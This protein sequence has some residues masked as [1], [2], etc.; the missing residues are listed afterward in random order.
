MTG[1]LTRVVVVEDEPVIALNLQQQLV[2]L[3][4]EVVGVAASGESALDQIV[5]QRPDVV[6]MDIR[7]EGELDGIETAARIPGDL[8]IVLIFL[9]G[10]F[11]DMTF[12][13]AREAKPYGFLVKP[14]SDW[15]LHA[16]IQMALDRRRIDAALRA[17]ERQL[18]ESNSRLRAEQ[19]TNL[20]LSLVATHTTNSVII[21]NSNGAIDWV[22]EA[23]T[24]TTGYSLAEVRGK[25]ALSLL[26]GPDS[27]P[28]TIALAR[29]RILLGEG[30]R[31]LELLNYT[32]AGEPYWVNV[33]ALPIRDADGT[34]VQIVSIGT[35]VTARKAAEAEIKASYDKFAGSFHRSTEAMAVFTIGA[36][37]G[38]GI[39]K[40]LN[41]AAERLF[42]VSRDDVIGRTVLEFPVFVDS[43]QIMEC[44]QQLRSEG[45]L[46]DYSI[47][48]RRSDG[49]T[50]AG[51]ITASPFL[52]AGQPHLIVIFRDVTE[53]RAAERR[54]RELNQSLEA[55]LRQ[56]RAIADNVPASIVYLDAEERYRFMNL[57]AERWLATKFE[58]VEGR[59]I[60]ETMPENYVR[61]VH[62]RHDRLAGGDTHEEMSIHH[63]DGTTRTVDVAYVP[64]IDDS[65]LIRGYYQLAI[66]ISERKAMEER[67]RQSQTLEAIGRL[68][69]GVAHDFNNILAVILANL[70]LLE[71]EIADRPDSLE[72]LQ[73]AI[74]ATIHGCSLTQRLLLIASRQPLH[75]DHVAIGALV[76][77]LVRLFRSTLSEQH[78]IEMKSDP[79]AG[80]AFVDPGALESALLNLVVN[81]R[82]AMPDG[83][84]I[85]IRVTPVT[86][87]PKTVRAIPDMAEGDY[88]RIS[89]GDSGTGMTPEVEARAFDPFFTTKPTGKGTGLGLSMVYG[90]VKQSGGR[91]LI[92]S[93]PGTGTVASIYLPKAMPRLKAAHEA[94]EMTPNAS[95][96]GHIL[97]VEDNADLR[98]SLAMQLKNA[99]HRVT[100]VAGAAE[101]FDAI[102][103]GSL[104]DLV[105]TDIGLPGAMNGIQM[106]E[107]LRG[108]HTDLPVI[109]MSGYIQ[110]AG[111]VGRLAALRCV[112]LRKPFAK[113]EMIEAV[114]KC[115]SGATLRQGDQPVRGE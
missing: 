44:L 7:I 90:F 71:T 17:S 56:I 107:I 87:G 70:E 25:G 48:L 5:A 69:G 68:T 73:A 31:D 24:R 21:S 20:R 42:V 93:T 72:L 32:K 86:I 63:P 3:G 39:L 66:D 18:A 23:F 35:N 96:T 14:C 84:T 1:S 102:N 78:V 57:T 111:F 38:S 79:E 6:L 91:V 15:G 100:A 101:A 115:F 55:K 45:S 49:S 27:D 75:P 81:A 65:G 53:A 47:T 12:E 46:R 64:D 4:Y 108:R 13:R 92:E 30:Y 58:E 16:T 41:E 2:D 76:G 112:L 109:F 83:G 19:E 77:D 29:E 22:N 110:D 50:I 28:A 89:V 11:E 54:I 8:D 61:T 74:R 82:D 103:S 33:E 99:G 85:S 95:A 114:G 62:E 40:D 94:R 52:A 67:L 36:E 97:L 60:E 104:P 34:L 9:T 59:T 106:V 37:P 26:R 10:Y 43:D 98:N 88:V 51:L 105:L 80:E 113:S